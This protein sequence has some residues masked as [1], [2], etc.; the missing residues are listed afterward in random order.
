MPLRLTTCRPTRLP[1][2]RDRHLRRDRP[3]LGVRR[4]A[5][6]PRQR[7][8]P[9]PPTGH[10]TRPHRPACR[11]PPPPDRRPRTAARRRD[12][13]PATPRHLGRHSPRARHHQTSRPT[14]LHPALTSIGASIG[15]R[16]TWLLL[17]TPE[18]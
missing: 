5:Q 1:A 15:Q 2:H 14:A 13:C 12:P 8:D 18:L 7:S 3:L 11:R 17:T 4:T 10:P 9:P 16:S 6:H